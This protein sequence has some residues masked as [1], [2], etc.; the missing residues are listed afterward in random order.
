MNDTGKHIVSGFRELRKFCRSA[1]LLLKTATGM[2]EDDEWNLRKPLVVFNGGRRID[3]PDWWLP[4]DLCRFFEKPG[5][6][7]LLPYIAVN[8]NDPETCS[9]LIILFFQPVVSFF[10]QARNMQRCHTGGLAGIFSWLNE[11]K[12]MVV[13][14]S[15]C[16]RRPGNSRTVGKNLR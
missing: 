9:R 3:A 5:R 12:T 1:A 6:P 4:Y 8:L 11:E 10:K 2:M 7:R 16:R 13:S 14:V 15:T